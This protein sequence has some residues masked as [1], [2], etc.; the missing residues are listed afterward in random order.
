MHLQFI[1]GWVL[2]LIWPALLA[3]AF[4][5]FLFRRKQTAL[6]AFLADPMLMK[7][8]PSIKPARFYWQIILF[9]TGLILTLVAA[10]RPQWGREEKIVFQRGRDLVIALDVSRSMLARDVHPDRLRRA[11]ADILDLLRELRGDRVALI[12][13]RGKAIQLCPLTIDYAYFEQILNEVNI[14]SAPRGETNIG[15]AIYKAMTAFESDEGSHRALII[16]S[17]GEDLAGEARTAAQK[18]KEKGIVIFTVGLGDP[19]GTVI[20]GASKS[21][22]NL[23][24]QGKEVITSLHHD[25]LREI[26]EITGGA[27]VPVGVANV[28]LGKLYSDH[29]SKISARDMEESLQSRMIERFPLFLF[30][31]MIAL[32][33]G[34]FL[35][36]GRLAARKKTT[37]S[38]GGHSAVFFPFLKTTK[39]FVYLAFLPLIFPAGNLLADTNQGMA[40]ATTAGLIPAAVP[41]AE[42]LAVTD[43]TTTVQTSNGRDKTRPSTTIMESN[44]VEGHASSCP[45]I[46]TNNYFCSGRTGAYKA[47][48]Y[49][50]LGDYDKS[51][52][53]YLHAMKEA[54]QRLQDD[55]LFNAGCAY[56]QGHN[57]PAAMNCFSQLSSREN[58]DQSKTYYN[59]G[60]ATY[61][62]AEQA[63]K[64]ETNAAPALKPEL[65][66]KA[67][68]AFQRAWR[69]K[70]DFS[71]A[72][73]NLAVVTNMLPKAR[74]E[75]RLR[76]LLAKYGN[77]PP[78]QI[79]DTVLQNQRNIGKALSPALTNSTPARLGEFE[80]LAEQQR[81]NTDLL[82][83]LKI[84]LANA[85]ITPGSNSQQQIQ[86]LNQHLEAMQNSMDEAYKNLRDIDNRSFHPVTS[87]ERGIYILWKG[88][89]DFSQLLQED[90]R[91][92]T[93]TICMTTSIL[94][95]VEADLSRRSALAEAEQN[96]AHQLTQLFVERFSKEVPPEG[97]A[98][99]KKLPGAHPAAPLP[100]ANTAAQT[101]N[102][103]PQISAETRTNILNLAQQ[104]IRAQSAA[105]A[106]LN[107]TNVE[108]S[109]PEQRRAYDLLKEIERLLPKNKNQQQNQQNQDEQQNQQKDQQKDQ[110]Q[111]KQDEQK[112]PPQA[113]PPKQ[114][115]QKPQP[116]KEQPSG[117]EK[118]D[119]KE[120]TAEQLRAL[121]DKA[122]QREKEHREEK[123]RNEYI[124]PS[125]VDRDW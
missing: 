80:A 51:A 70:P 113:E 119:E 3:A 20:P 120:M 34:A 41:A 77:Q 37:A 110:E 93:N 15:D 83:P 84:S 50:H 1:N 89:A 60:C 108:F 17:D 33:A 114:E 45:R 64:Q 102:E 59:L 65:L 79:A 38:T 107:V 105:S 22:P 42:T 11:K 104:A 36:R 39:F 78:A 106:Y 101:T 56:Y 27:Y 87:S 61:R 19:K 30:P 48:R 75:A 88:L 86:Q 32:L 13:F 72:A 25:T 96:E 92:Q 31:G 112:P 21:E 8:A 125:P 7:L 62:M 91:R 71:H 52:A 124:P 100:P 109:L 14:E 94:A 98:E 82:I 95:K 73:E 46:T 58:I 115:E 66:E 76:S 90:I 118:K 57:F 116:P 47:Q 68:I 117:Q 123:M 103:A 44:I 49:Y 53:A 18:A 6:R 16:I 55:C 122:Q 5:V 9:F 24:Y 111:Q 10:A 43:G 121:L 99:S 23:R 35:S 12:T 97:T 40:T 63:E 4:S 67:G 29:L 85:M 26:S 74:E 28:K 2:L 69:A 54:N 81:N